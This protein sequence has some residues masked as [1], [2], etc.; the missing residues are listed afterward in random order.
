MEEH[1]RPYGCTFLSCNKIFSSK[2]KWRRHENSQH[3]HLEIWRCCEVKP[4]LTK[5][6]KVCYKRTTFEEHLKNDHNISEER[7]I[8]TTADDNRLGRNCQV[9]F[10][11]GFC[12]KCIDQ[13]SKG[14]EAWTERFDHLEN[15]FIGRGIPKQNIRE[16][17]SVDSNKSKGDLGTIFEDDLDDE[18][19][20]EHG[21]SM[22]CLSDATRKPKESHLRSRI[23]AG[24]KRQ[25]VGNEEDIDSEP[26]TKQRR[27]FRAS[28]VTVDAEPSITPN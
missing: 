28:S 15:H 9:R 2:K 8:K 24:S 13:K 5:C 25:I 12:D 19:G 6:I 3:F 16:L 27:L 4:D 22:G 17:I 11:C 18:S 10:W 21:S 20:S 7:T 1:E 23:S 14:L 26:R